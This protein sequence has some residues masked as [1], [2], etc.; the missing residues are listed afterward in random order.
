MYSKLKEEYKDEF[1]DKI[2]SEFETGISIIQVQ[3]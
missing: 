3:H 1:F 2:L